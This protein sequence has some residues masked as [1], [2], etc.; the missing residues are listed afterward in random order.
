LNK[1]D[2]GVVDALHASQANFY[3]QLERRTD[4]DKSLR[5]IHSVVRGEVMSLLEKMD[6]LAKK[7][8]DFAECICYP[9]LNSDRLDLILDL[10]NEVTIQLWGQYGRKNPNI[11]ELAQSAEL[12]VKTL[13]YQKLQFALS[14]E[15]FSLNPQ[16]S[17]SSHQNP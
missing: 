6:E 17:S 11:L 15:L 8:P 1:S 3:E 9:I 7:K 2:S 16:T 12:A 14:E 13:V 10:S 5:P 4:L